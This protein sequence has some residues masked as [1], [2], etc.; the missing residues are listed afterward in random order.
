[1]LFPKLWEEELVKRKGLSSRLSP[2]HCSER[3]CSSSG[4]LEGGR[5][6]CV[7]VCAHV[8]K[9]VS[10][11]SEQDGPNTKRMRR[12]W[13]RASGEEWAGTSVLP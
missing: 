11:C 12:L 2:G 3:L 6:L 13:W 5:Y 1:M 8:W 4:L 9:R 7:P 10:L